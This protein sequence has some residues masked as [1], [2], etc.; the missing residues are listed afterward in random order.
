MELVATF[1]QL[2]TIERYICIKT[3]QD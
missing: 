2:C 3:T 1:G